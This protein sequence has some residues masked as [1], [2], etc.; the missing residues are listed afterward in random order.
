MT[1]EFSHIHLDTIGGI[2]GDMFVAAMLDA[3]P[4][5]RDRVLAD[6]TA[7]L[8][9][10]A[11]QPRLQERQAGA[12]RAL[13]FSLAGGKPHE[14]ER[15]HH[16]H[17][18]AG[19]FRDMVDHIR[20][21]KLGEDTTARAVAILTHL[22]QA[23]AR[24]HDV[25]LD[26]VHFHEI[27]DWDSL[28]DVVAAGSIAAALPGAVWSV[29]ELPRGGGVVRTQHGMLPV[30]AP[31]TAM[32]LEGFVWRDDGIAGERVTPTGAAILRH[33]VGAGA[34]KARAAGRLAASGAGCGSRELPGLPNILRALVFARET[35]MSSPAPA[36]GRGAPT[37]AEQVAVLSLDID[38]MT[39]EEIGAAADRLR[40]EPGVLDL[41]VGTR[42]GK[43]GRPL[44]DFRLLVQ[45][46]LLD[47]VKLQA[48]NETSTIGL[49]WRFEDRVVLPRRARDERVE[50]G[51]VRVKEVTRPDGSVSSKAESDDLHALPSLQ[52]RRAAKA[53]AEGGS[54]A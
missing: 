22:A 17:S 5:V 24:I 46:A 41:S 50:Q 23:E 40:A 21:A 20:A 37:E 2:G 15:G 33:L 19:S 9:K 4:A 32:I 16:S 31:A 48:L 26:R 51:V 8:P 43:K 53:D 54:G 29:S 49:R 34:P 12:V 38:D 14:H 7:V 36:P 13:H 47:H 10:E 6:V 25:P 18:N 11:G 3:L 27:A 28:M 45:P 42:I 39:G 1:A 30:P 35:V 52:R 44:H